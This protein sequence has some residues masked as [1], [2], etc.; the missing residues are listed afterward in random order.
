MSQMLVHFKRKKSFI[1]VFVQVQ[2]WSDFGLP[3]SLLKSIGPLILLVSGQSS[4]HTRTLVVVTP[5]FQYS[6]YP[7]CSIQDFWKIPQFILIDVVFQGPLGRSP[8]IKK[9]TRLRLV[10]L[11]CLYTIASFYSAVGLCNLAFEQVRGVYKLPFPFF[12]SCLF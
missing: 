9:C 4:G 1:K 7:T 2:K 11:F 12:L 5:G 8:D 3:K 10:S 6:H